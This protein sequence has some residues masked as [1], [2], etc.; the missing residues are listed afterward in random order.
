MSTVV[1]IRELY[2]RRYALAPLCAVC[3]IYGAVSFYCL[4]MLPLP[5]TR[6]SSRLLVVPP[7]KSSFPLLD[8]LYCSKT[9]HIR[10]PPK[11]YDY[12][13]MKL[14]RAGRMK[15]LTLNRDSVEL[16]SYPGTTPKP[17]FSQV[18]TMKG[19]TA[20]TKNRG[21]TDYIQF[22]MNSKATAYQVRCYT[23]EDEVVHPTRY[24]LEHI[25][26]KAKIRLR[27]RAS[28]IQ[29]SLPVSEIKTDPQLMP[30]SHRRSSTQLLSETHRNAEHEKPKKAVHL[31]LK[32]ATTSKLP[33]TKPVKRIKHLPK[34]PF[35]VH[36]TYESDFKQKYIC[37]E[38]AIDWMRINNSK[39]KASV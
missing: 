10:S 25:V 21:F 28:H 5:S 13:Q 22:Y 11:K 36:K 23:N 35:G 8:L 1:L 15:K 29:L 4:E 19:S 27:R 3:S 16:I 6:V 9:S 37:E 32:S 20:S 26:D 34:S 14:Q 33:S 7:Q 18:S 24:T 30:A 31:T 2:K 12:S 38:V 17:P 39:R